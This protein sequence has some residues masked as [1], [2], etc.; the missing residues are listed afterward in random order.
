MKN[1]IVVVSL[2]IVVI[3]SG[4]LYPYLEDVMQQKNLKKEIQVTMHLF[5]LPNLDYDQI[6]EHLS[7]T[8]S[9]GEYQK[10]EEATKNYC[11]DYLIFLLEVLS[12]LDSHPE[13]RFLTI[14]NIKQD[15][16]DFSKTKE[17]FAQVEHKITDLNKQYQQITSEKKMLS[18]GEKQNLSE[19][20]FDFYKTEIV[21]RKENKQTLEEVL[22]RTLY[23]LKIEKQIITL[24]SNRRN[25]WELQDETLQFSDNT[26]KEKYEK[27][28]E[29]HS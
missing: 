22:K 4:F 6:L 11:M 18:Y 17:A 1:K 14:E 3:L 20:Y 26:T 10:V 27:L 15:G 29:K 21:G 28:I 12:L 9:K 25:D 13:S 5:Q 23:D 24:L 8:V 2:V 16:K 19:K 7:H